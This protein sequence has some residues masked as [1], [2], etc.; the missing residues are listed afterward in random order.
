MGGARRVSGGKPDPGLE[1]PRPQGLCPTQGQV[2]GA[3]LP[4][5]GAK[6]GPSER[7]PGRALGRGPSRR[8]LPALLCQ[9]T[10]VEELLLETAA[11]CG[12]PS[13][14]PILLL[15]SSSPWPW[16]LL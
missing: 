9:P 10:T 7:A 6:S 13:P 15:D 12:R 3:L 14:V 11:L 2:G 8:P 4:P 1:P 5:E 16:G